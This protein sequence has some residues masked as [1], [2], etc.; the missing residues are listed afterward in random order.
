MLVVCSFGTATRDDSRSRVKGPGPANYTIQT[1]VGR[2]G[3]SY[4]LTPR[5]PDTAPA[6]GRNVPGPGSYRPESAKDPKRA[7]P[8]FSFGT[9]ER[10]NSMDRTAAP[11]AGSYQ[12]Q[13]TI[14]IAPNVRVIFQISL[15]GHLRK[16]LD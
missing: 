5:R 4:Y 15:G 1:G 13:S 12:I 2:S 11:G 8:S 9:G 3:P 6:R 16:K 7:A 10:G 14:G